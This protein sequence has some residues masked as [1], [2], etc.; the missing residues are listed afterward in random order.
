M[1]Q[2][3]T[4][5]QPIC[6]ANRNAYSSPRIRDLPKAERAPFEKWLTGQTCPWLKDVAAEEQDAYYPWDYTTWKQQQI[7]KKNRHEFPSVG[8]KM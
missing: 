8:Y 7:C 3:P 2:P 4:V 5:K 6:E 1:K